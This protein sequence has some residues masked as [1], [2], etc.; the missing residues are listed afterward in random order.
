[1][2][3]FFPGLFEEAQRHELPVCPV[4]I[5]YPDPGDAWVEEAPFV[6]HFLERF[7]KPWIEVHVAFGA[8]V[9]AGEVADLR[10]HAR[11]WIRGALDER[12]RCFARS[13]GAVAQA[14]P[15]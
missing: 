4:A 9:R 7:R 12:E 1:V 5:S 3:T 11:D 6:P 14:V 13:F 10:E 15:A 2:R 8:P